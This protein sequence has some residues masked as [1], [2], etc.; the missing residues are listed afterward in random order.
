MKDSPI[1][2]YDSAYHNTFIMGVHTKY[3]GLFFKLY[4]PIYSQKF[5]VKIS[6]N[7]SIFLQLLRKKKIVLKLLLNVYFNE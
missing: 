6:K 5:N 4:F 3:H 2:K 1:T 7:L